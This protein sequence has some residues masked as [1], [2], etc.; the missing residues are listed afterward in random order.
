MHVSLEVWFS[1]MESQ[2]DKKLNWLKWTERSSI[3]HSRSSIIL[4]PAS[5]CHCLFFLLFFLFFSLNNLACQIKTPRWRR[6]GGPDLQGP[7]WLTIDKWM[8]D[9][10]RMNGLKWNLWTLSSLTIW[11]KGAT[12]ANG[13]RWMES[14]M[15]Q[16][17]NRN[18]G[19]EETCR[20]VWQSTAGPVG[21]A[22]HPHGT[23][24]SRTSPER[25]QENE[26]VKLF[27][28]AHTYSKLQ[29][30]RFLALNRWFSAGFDSRL[31]FWTS[32]SSTRFI[33]YTKVNRFMLKITH[34]ID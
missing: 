7:S 29:K 4:K 1:R 18:R 21:G 2:L 16:I 30:L 11:A 34:E 10:G 31:K 28:S 25:E 3:I 8:K 27:H 13:K 19:I 15:L 32:N 17:G 14:G 20:A 12:G 33:Y 22:L 24:R 5:F 23:F 6:N 26:S 9:A